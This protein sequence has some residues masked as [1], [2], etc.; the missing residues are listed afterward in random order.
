[1]I[2]EFPTAFSPEQARTLLST[3]KL[4]AKC[5]K[6]WSGAILYF[7]GTDLRPGIGEDSRYAM[8]YL[9]KDRSDFSA[10]GAEWAVIDDDKRSDNHHTFASIYYDARANAFDFLGA[11]QTIHV[12][13][14]GSLGIEFNTARPCVQHTLEE[15]A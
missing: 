2:P 3:L 10:I 8:M 1:M 6:L 9:R 14:N 12:P 4:R 13:V 15:F 7:S 5:P 11:R